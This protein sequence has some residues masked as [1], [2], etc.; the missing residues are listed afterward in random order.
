VITLDGAGMLAR[1]TTNP[2]EADPVVVQETSDP[3]AC[4]G[5]EV[6]A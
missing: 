5:P 6:G 2:P 4:F 1:Y 3:M